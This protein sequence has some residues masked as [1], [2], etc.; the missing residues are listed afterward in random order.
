V[1]PWQL[2]EEQELPYGPPFDACIAFDR[3]LA[4]AFCFP[5]IDPRCTHSRLLEEAPLAAEHT[6]C[7]AEAR[8]LLAE[9]RDVEADAGPA[10]SAGTLRLRT[11]ARLR[12]YLTQPFLVQEPFSGRP[13]AS[14]PLPTLLAD[15]RALLDGRADGLDVEQLSYR[16]ALD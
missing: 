5:A 9:L 8:T 2:V 11:A 7:A 1:A 3:A 10:A 14:V 16:G 4:E 12:A 15:V 13:G 6:S